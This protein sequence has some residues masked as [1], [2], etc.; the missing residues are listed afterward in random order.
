MNKLIPG[1]TTRW[2]TCF[3]FERNYIHKHHDLGYLRQRCRH[4]HIPN[5]TEK[6]FGFTDDRITVPRIEFGYGVAGI[7]TTF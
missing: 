3:L 4:P 2:K 6:C 1:P 7:S 5:H